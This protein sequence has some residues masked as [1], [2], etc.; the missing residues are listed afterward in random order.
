MWDVHFLTTD[1]TLY[2]T[3]DVFSRKLKCRYV[4]EETQHI[5]VFLKVK[6]SDYS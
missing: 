2:C 6:L 1:C 4:K 5:I 3:F